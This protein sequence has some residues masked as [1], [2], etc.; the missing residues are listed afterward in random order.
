M[1]TFFTHKSIFEQASLRGL[2]FC[3]QYRP[4]CFDY[5]VYSE[6]IIN[7]RMTKTML[8]ISSNNMSLSYSHPFCEPSTPPSLRNW[9]LERIERYFEDKLQMNNRWTG[10]HQLKK[11]AEI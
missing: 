5:V 7:V 2:G 4:V 3:S 1:S 8:L 6:M 11:G 10:F 9:P